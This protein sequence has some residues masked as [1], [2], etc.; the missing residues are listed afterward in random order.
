MQHNKNFFQAKCGPK[1]EQRFYSIEQLII[2]N[3]LI[4]LLKCFFKYQNKTIIGKVYKDLTVQ[5]GLG[6]LDN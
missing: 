2:Y 4:F 6:A 3:L 5:F 1:N